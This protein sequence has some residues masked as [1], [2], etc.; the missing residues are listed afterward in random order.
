MRAQSVGI[1]LAVLS[2]KDEGKVFRFAVE[3]E[4]GRVDCLVGGR[5]ACD[6]VLS[7]PSVS[8][9]HFELA[10]EG[11]GVRLR[12]LRS[13]NGLWIG[14]ARIDEAWLA[15][16]CEFFAGQ[17]RIRVSEIDMQQMPVSTQKTLGT[18]AGASEASRALFSLLERVAP[19]PMTVLVMGESGVGK[20]EVARTIHAESGR[21]G[22]FHLLD[23]STLPRELSAALVLGHSKGA[24]TGASSDR[25]GPFEL[26]D[27]GTLFLDEVGELPLDAQQN[28]LTVVDRG[29]LQRVGE[30]RVRKVNVRI[31]AAT[32]RN[33]AEEVAAGRFRQDLYFRLRQFVI[34][35]PPLRD[36]PEDIDHLAEA[37]LVEFGKDAGRTLRLSPEA[38][39]ELRRP[40]WDGNVRQLRD[41]MRRAAYLSS[42]DVVAVA[43]LNMFDDEVWVDRDEV[44]MQDNEVSVAGGLKT[45]TE[46]FQ[47]RYCERLLASVDG[48]ATKAA[49]LAKYTPRGFS[50]LLERLGLPDR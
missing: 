11:K 30:T 33:L 47:R 19:T 41:V 34:T 48:D 16:G 8:T 46:A 40:R 7:D 20:G 42:G 44:S 18:M 43:D 9:R 38:Q 14:R 10:F 5:N 49:T 6:I 1:S 15:P 32:N 17:C 13:R 50:I 28:L 27:G 29:E 4:S 39:A 12:D 36:R 31:V 26:A 37:F 25:P 22:P 2:G 45:A 24:F 35:V 23:C 21:T 3:G